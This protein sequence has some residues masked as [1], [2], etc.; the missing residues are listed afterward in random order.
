MLNFAP[1]EEQEEIRQLAQTIALEQLRPQGR[2]AEKQGDIS[3]EL[4]KTLA[5]TGL[6]T[7][8][9]EEYGGSGTIEA[10]TYTLIVEELGFGDGSLAMNI[11]GSL[12]GPLTVLLAGEK[13]QQEHYIAPFCDAQKGHLQRGSLAFAERTGGYTVE[14]ISANVREEGVNY[15]LNGSKRNVFHGGQSSPRVVLV[16]LEGSS[17]TGGLCALM[18][19]LDSA[20]VHVSQ[21]VEKLGLIAAPGAAFTFENASI[22][23]SCMLGKPGNSGVIR[24]A[25]LYNILRA[26]VACGT[27]RAAL[28]YAK[29]YAKGRIAFGRPIVSYQGIAF[30]IAE[31]AM[32]L[33]AA[34]LLT[35]QAAASWDQGRDT[36]DPYK[37]AEAAQYQAIKIAKSATIDAIQILGGA[38]FIQDHPAEMWMRNAAA[39]E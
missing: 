20:G 17:G 5:Q 13:S 24:A 33:D 36:S 14:E 10:V 35:W 21:D 38:G 2:S 39:M 25:A 6:T 29:E 9:P 31:M 22:S 26:A 18:V 11:I 1:T 28:D 34:R 32:K 30:M 19:P 23:A 7:P 8:F 4:M 27:A 12:M 15:I 37:E 3:P 16:R